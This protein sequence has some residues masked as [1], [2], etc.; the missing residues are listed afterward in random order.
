[1]WL[2]SYDVA[3]C[4]E[5]SIKSNLVICVILRKDLSHPSCH[6]SVIRLDSV[7]SKWI[8]YFG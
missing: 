1:M 8:L 2:T 5:T 7:L 6:I 4:S 3:K